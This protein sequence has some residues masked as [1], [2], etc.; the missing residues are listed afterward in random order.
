MSTVPR[1]PAIQPRALEVDILVPKLDSPLGSRAA[2]LTS[3]RQLEVAG[4]LVPD[5]SLL[6]IANALGAHSKGKS[7]IHC[8]PRKG[9]H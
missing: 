2:V 7:S 4:T 3:A 5:W 8:C 9:G 6:L 1:L